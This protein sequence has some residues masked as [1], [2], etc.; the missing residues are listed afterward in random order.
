MSGTRISDLPVKLQPVETDLVPIVDTSNPDDLITKQTTIGAIL[1][2]LITSAQNGAPGGV[3][4]LDDS[5]LIPVSQLPPEALTSAASA[6]TT[7]ATGPAGLVGPRGATGPAGLDGATGL[8]GLDGAAGEPGPAGAT[9]PVGPQGL[10]IHGPTGA[11]GVAGPTGVAGATGSR[12]ATGPAPTVY[13]VAGEPDKIIVGTVLVQAA[14]GTTGPAGPTGAT[15]PAGYIGRDGSTGPT[16]VGITG[17]TGAAGPQ[18]PT[19]PAGTIEGNIYA[20]GVLFDYAPLGFSDVDAALRAVLE[21]G[22]GGGTTPE[23]TVSLTN[24]VNQL[25]RGQTL[26]NITLNWSVSGAIISSQSL[27]DVGTIASSLRTYAFSALNLS[28]VLSKTWTLTYTLAFLNSAA[29]QNGTKT[30]SVLWS[31]KIFWGVSDAGIDSITDAQ[32]QA[33]NNAFSATITQTRIFN[34]TN[35]Y[36]YFAW[37]SALGLASFFKFNGF[38]NSAWQRRTRNFTNSYGASVEYHIYQSDFKQSGANI[39]IEVS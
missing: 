8:A 7:G 25:E 3:A 2:N 24:N 20:T 19:G 27:T 35:Q 14:Q 9:G 30:T 1:R 21:S 38:V 5:G 39:L 17:A 31:D 22:G 6:G 13:P 36:I 16:G 10:T 33:F 32:I 18:G 28:N 4:S 26:N 15:G 11:T 12:G 37:P 23:A 34:P 29:T